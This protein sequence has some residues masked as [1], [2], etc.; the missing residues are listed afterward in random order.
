MFGG[1]NIVNVFGCLVLQVVIR[2]KIRVVQAVVGAKAVAKG[3][4]IVVVETGAATILVE[5]TS[6]IM[7]A[8]R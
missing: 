3:G 4:T 7:A 8:D 2:G 6:R 1:L 5:A